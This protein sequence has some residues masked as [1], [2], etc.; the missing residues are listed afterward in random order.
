MLEIGWI[1][2]SKEHQNKV[3]SIL[4]MLLKPGAVDELGI[5]TIRDRFAD[6]FFPGTSTIQTRA[7][8]FFIVPWILSELE[9]EKGLN[10]QQFARKLHD[11]EIKLIDKLIAD[12]SWGVIGVDSREKLKRKP[13]D[14]YWNGLRTYDIMKYP[15][16]TI[17]EYIAAACAARDA[18]EKRKKELKLEVKDGIG[19]K[20]DKD[21]FGAEALGVFWSTTIPKTNWRNDINMKLSPGEALFLKDKIITSPFSKDSLWAE[22]LRNF[23][24]E[25]INLDSYEKLGEIVKD[26]PEQI[27][28]DYKLA[29]KFSRLIYGA[30][31]RY[32]ILFFNSSGKESSVAKEEWEAWKY[33][34]L[35][36]FDF[37]SWDVDELFSRLRI[38]DRPLRAFIR[39]WSDFTKSINNIDDQI[40]DDFIIKREIQLKGPER[41]KL[42]NADENTNFQGNWIGISRLEYRWPNA[43]R[44]L[45]DIIEGLGEEDV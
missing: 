42:K 39:N 36:D 16:L 34:M 3:M 33:E 20:D 35:N 22:I 38:Y 9:K 13:S 10:P 37:K 19:D 2:F 1:D 5:S 17:S 24:A 12:G 23:S 7:K 29:S 32:N 30:H 26:M 15:K 6:I 41:S 4:D 40:L 14:I 43:N 8:Y 25:A 21:A 45:R 11:E 18:N 28:G 27:Y 44:L 31:A